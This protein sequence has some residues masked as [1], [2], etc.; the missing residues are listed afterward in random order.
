MI[1]FIRQVYSR[2]GS[3]ILTF[4]AYRTYRGVNYW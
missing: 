4:K 2:T 3:V 1:N